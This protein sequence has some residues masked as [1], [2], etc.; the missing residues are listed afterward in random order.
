MPVPLK[1]IPEN[2]IST[3]VL[4]AQLRSSGQIMAADRMEEM[5]S[6]IDGAYPIVEAWAA[7][8]PGQT[9]WR[10]QWKHNAIVCGAEPVW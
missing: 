10:K 1:P 8:G 2:A 5:L 3:E 9:D 4:V 6:L 7:E